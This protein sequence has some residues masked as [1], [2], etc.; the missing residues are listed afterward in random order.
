[1]K[2]DWSANPHA[3]PLAVNIPMKAF[4]H[5]SPKSSPSSYISGFNKPAAAV[6]P[7][8][9]ISSEAT[10]NASVLGS[11]KKG[12]VSDFSFTLPASSSSMPSIIKPRTS[13]S[14]IARMYKAAG[15]KLPQSNTK[16]S[17]SNYG[18]FDVKPPSFPVTK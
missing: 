10:A 11:L 4:Q 2:D 18:R 12:A 15:F 9:Q 16:P 17:K 13:Q 5:G 3:A 7:Y 6:A 1:M 8:L 14:D